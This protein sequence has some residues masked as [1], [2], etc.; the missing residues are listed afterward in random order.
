MPYLDQQNLTS[1]EQ[2]TVTYP[3]GSQTLPGYLLRPEEPG[4]FPTILFEPG[5]FGLLP[6]HL[7]GIEALRSMGYAVFVA[8]RRGHRGNDGPNWRP[9][10]TATWGTS[11]MGKQ[12]TEALLAEMED[13]VAAL[14][15]L[16]AQPEVNPERIAIVGHSFG[17]AVS[18]LATRRTRSV[19]AGISFAGPTPA[20][21]EAPAMQE[22][23]LDAIEYLTIP[24]FFVQAQNDHTLLPTYTFG[25][26]LARL[27]KPHETRIYPALGT[28]PAEGHNLF[29]KGVEWWHADVERFLARWLS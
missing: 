6:S 7:L 29:G 20:W 19:R 26:H 4:S 8:L 2:F 1:L 14:E 9:H 18:L 27:K 3:S 17:A 22:A 21:R 10:V 25:M 5:S 13:V 12:L 28:A 16:Q 15:W 24:F 23:L 11:R